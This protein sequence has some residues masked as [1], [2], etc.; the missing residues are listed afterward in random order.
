MLLNV[1]TSCWFGYANEIEFFAEF[2]NLNLIGT[3]ENSDREEVVYLSGRNDLLEDPACGIYL[4][5][6]LRNDDIAYFANLTLLEKVCLMNDERCSGNDF[7]TF[8]ETNYPHREKSV[9][10]QGFFWE[11]FFSN[12]LHRERS[13]FGSILEWRYSRMKQLYTAVLKISYFQRTSSLFVVDDMHSIT[14]LEWSARA[15]RCIRSVGLLTKISFYDSMNVI[16][17]LVFFC[18]LSLRREA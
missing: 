5:V 4:L 8:V 14:P 12:R 9:F 2:S 17:R 1:F 6:L 13:C 3:N 18:S 10:N 11:L 16:C 15:S 7:P